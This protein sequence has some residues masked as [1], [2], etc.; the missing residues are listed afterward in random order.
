MP[1]TEAVSDGLD[2]KL[3]LLQLDRIVL[4]KGLRDKG[5]LFI[6]TPFKKKKKKFK[7]LNLKYGLHQDLLKFPQTQT[8]MAERGF[9]N[10]L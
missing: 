5:Y 3:A 8:V 10:L 9:T 1:S 6:T 4:A 7:P 2:P